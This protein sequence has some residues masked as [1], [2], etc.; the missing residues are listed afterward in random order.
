LRGK[1]VG[2]PRGF[3]EGRWPW[4]MKSLPGTG[5]AHIKEKEIKRYEREGKMRI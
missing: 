2:L 3:S 5:R 4:K 1:E